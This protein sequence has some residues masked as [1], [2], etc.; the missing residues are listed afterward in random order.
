MSDISREVRSCKV[1]SLAS[2]CKTKSRACSVGTEV[3]RLTTSKDAKMSLGPTHWLRI[4]FAN[5]LEFFTLYGFFKRGETIL[6]KNL[7]RL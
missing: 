6:H 3:K 7:E 5:S 2:N 4:K 1:L